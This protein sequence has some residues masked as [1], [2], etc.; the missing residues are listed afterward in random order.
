MRQQVDSI[1]A[2]IRP[3][4]LRDGGD[5]EV[6]KIEDGLVYVKMLGACDGCIALDITLKQGIERMLLENIPGI[7]GVV[8]V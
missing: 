8:N 2:K 5:I 4:I 7:I 3:Y 6:L 1:I